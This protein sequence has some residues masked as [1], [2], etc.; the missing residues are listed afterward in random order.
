MLAPSPSLA[1]C[2]VTNVSVSPSLSHPLTQLY[3][4][5][6]NSSPHDRLQEHRFLRAGTWSTK[7]CY[8]PGPTFFNV[9]KAYA[10][11]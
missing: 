4:T 3:F 6:Q 2:L 9:K 7:H 8:S 11:T 10:S 1:L 5:S